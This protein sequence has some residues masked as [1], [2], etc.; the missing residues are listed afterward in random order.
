MMNIFYKNYYE[1]PQK[2]TFN[3]LKDKDLDPHCRVRTGWII[4]CA[5]AYLQKVKFKLIVLKVQILSGRQLLP[6]GGI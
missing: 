4:K 1:I 3:L 6:M 5:S 2:G